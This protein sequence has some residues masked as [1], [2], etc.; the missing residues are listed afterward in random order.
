MVLDSCRCWLMVCVSLGSRGARGCSFTLR[1]SDERAREQEN[2]GE[3]KT[4]C[5]I[6]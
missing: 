4:E 2:R 5:G 6:G 3:A 1:V